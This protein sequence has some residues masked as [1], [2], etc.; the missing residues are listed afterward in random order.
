M[1]ALCPQESWEK[2][3]SVILTFTNCQMSKTFSIFLCKSHSGTPSHVSTQVF[4]FVL[5]V[6]C[7]VVYLKQHEP[8]ES[9]HFYY[10]K[11]DRLLCVICSVACVPA[12][13]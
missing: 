11:I 13:C 12:L 3:F 7:V 2:M 5:V 4:L 10:V 8:C 9:C 1:C 6:L